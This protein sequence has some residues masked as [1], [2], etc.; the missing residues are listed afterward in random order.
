M[1]TQTLRPL[2]GYKAFAGP[3]VTIIMDGVGI[4]AQDESDGVYIAN[5]PVLDEL[6]QEP[7][8]VRLKAHGKAVGLPSDGDMGNS[9]VG[10]NALGSGRVFAQGAQL[11]NEALASGR[12]FAGDAWCE[13]QK[14]SRRGGT[15]H[16]IGLLSDGNV[17]SHI[18]QLNALLDRCVVEGFPRVRVHTLL[19]GRDVDQKSALRYVEPLEDKLAGCSVA[20]RD[21]RVAS[22][23]GRM[24]TT[25][26]RY[27]A[28]WAV[29]ANGWKAHVLGQGRF[30]SSASQAVRTFYTEDAEMTDQ[31][32][33][34]FCGG[35]CGPADRHNTGW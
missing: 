10:H 18:H 31:Y 32:M 15:I 20:G 28:N 33:A 3:V 21:Y 23:G 16:F 2:V 9:E 30:F 22:G 7:L 26:D 13:L 35:R 4:G 12:I 1:T 6:F 14:C 25:M 19:D 8:M 34:G 24:V 11:V 27:N 5:T 17:H 29:V